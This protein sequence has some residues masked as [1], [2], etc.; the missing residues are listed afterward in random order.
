MAK[1]AVPVPGAIEGEGKH[2]GRVGEAS[3]AD[4]TARPTRGVTAGV[5]RHMAT[6]YY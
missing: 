6:L 4:E 3:K 1:V 5:V 2:I